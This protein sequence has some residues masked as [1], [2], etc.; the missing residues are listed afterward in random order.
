VEDLRA[1][2]VANGDG[3]KQVAVLEMGWT[4]DEVQ[5]RLRL[6]RR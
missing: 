6:A 3:H 5:S 2:M 1:L 4:V